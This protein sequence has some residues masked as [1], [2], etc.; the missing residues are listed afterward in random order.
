[1]TWKTFVHSLEAEL[2]GRGVAF[3][4]LDVARFVEAEMLYVEAD[5]DVARWAAAF[6]E[7]HSAVDTPW[8]A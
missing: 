4:P 1:M 3:D 8:P 7:V 5:P 6:M 2:V